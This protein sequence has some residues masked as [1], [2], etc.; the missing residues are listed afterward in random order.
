MVLWSA[1]RLPAATTSVNVDRSRGDR[2]LGLTTGAGAIKAVE[3][4]RVSRPGAPPR[5]AQTER[6]VPPSPTRECRPCRVFAPHR[7]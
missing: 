4:P 7:K 5:G 6:A 2:V 3:R 1:F